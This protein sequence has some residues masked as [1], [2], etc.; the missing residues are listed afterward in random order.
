MRHP[1]PD[2]YRDPRARDASSIKAELVDA[3]IDSY[4]DWREEAAA[5][6]AAYRRWDRAAQCDR[7]LAFAAYRT[8]LDQE[9]RAAEHHAQ[10]IADY[11]RDRSPFRWA[12]AK[13]LRRR[14]GR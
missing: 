6:E 9:E 2:L 11:L 7:P 14:R 1:D 5:V 13:R 4:V 10:A 3:I 8:A 12:R